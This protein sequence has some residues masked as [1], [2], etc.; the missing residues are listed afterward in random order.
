VNLR[1]SRVVFLSAVV[2]AVWGVPAI[3]QTLN[4]TLAARHSAQ[5]GVA[6]KLLLEANSLVYD[7]KNNTVTAVG[8]VE[9]YYQGRALQADRVIYNRTTQRV[10]AS[11]N[12]RLTEAD[13]TVM[14]GDQ[15][16]ITD[17]FSDGFIDALR[18][19]TKDKTRFS[20]ARGERTLDDSLVF[21]KGI[22]TAC[23][24]CAKDPAKPP[25]WQ[26]K[27]KRIVHNNTD[28]TIYYE[29]AWM[30]FAGIPV[31][32][33]PF[34]WSPDP[35]VKR[36]TGFLVPNYIASSALGTGAKIPFFWN[37]APNKDLTLTPSFLSRQGVL[38]QAEW[39]HRIW[40]G[41][42]NIRVAGIFQQDKKA[43]QDTPLGAS[44]KD[45]RGSIESTGRFY[46]NPQWSTGWHVAAVTDKWFLGN[47]RIQSESIA[48][49]YFKESISTVYLRG[50]N[51]RTWFDLRAYH[52]KGL[53]TSD[54][55][56]HQ[57]WV[58]PSFDYNTRRDAPTWLGGTI[59]LDVNVTSLTRDAA[60]FQEIPR[61][62]TSLFTYRR[63]DGTTF[64]LYD[65]CAVFQRDKCILRGI[66]GNTT[67]A[68]VRMDWQREW[69]DPIGQVW[70]P[71][72]VVRADAFAVNLD[73]NSYNNNRMRDVV[74]NTEDNALRTMPAVGLM[75]RYP[76]YAPLS[77]GALGLNGS[78]VL[79]PIAQIVARPNERLIGKLP[80][81]DAQS[82]VFDDTSLF[83]W[84]K[85]SGYDRA[86]GGVRAN[87]GV[88]H[89]ATLSNGFAT[90]VLFGQSRNVAGRNSFAQ[91][92]YVNTGLDSG[93]ETKASDY[94]GRVQL[95]P[96][97]GLSFTGR[98]R[99]DESNFGMRRMELSANGA[100]GILSGSVTYARYQPQ[101]LLGYDKRREGLW[102]T[103]RVDVTKNWWLSGGALFD[104][105]RYLT[106]REN[107]K[108]ALQTDPNA[109]YRR[110]A[111]WAVASLS[112]GAGYQDECTT[113]G[114][115]Y[116]S[117][118]KDGATG[119][120]DTAQTIL[121]RLDL[122]TLGTAGFQQNVGLA[123]TQDGLR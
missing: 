59:G 15:F 82:L 115:T 80:N 98:G 100:Y 52:F 85:F 64:G 74:G 50:Q 33:A 36:K 106:D 103:A 46:L 23:E 14:T 58:H 105:D 73:E 10:F 35:T 120:R 91:G 6:D 4:E 51:E 42:Y 8:E 19:Q 88:Q 94:V 70:Q 34:F 113:F 96:W 31:A 71:Y 111:P 75:Y 60:H 11:G 102:T 83:S 92:D 13:G 87:Y 18:V 65:T 104:L 66:A 95:S 30:E 24:P 62:T 32:Y 47:Y 20:A 3:A 40:T 27:A 78:Q 41:A 76:L 16:D 61:S 110:S 44:D 12:A 97:T 48:N 37:I 49:N 21:T 56:K 84:D 5:K 118:V 26:V 54:W 57:P 55:Q 109:V 99:F 67:R 121:V 119:T 29:D 68:S 114:V 77:F 81:E 89:S 1:F 107:Y 17:N 38:G 117:S 2:L 93:L 122:R 39:R 9:L 108:F 101:P 72:A 63:R 43:F 53:A 123:T 112:L 28:K 45:F 116:I 7:N 86:E 69:I 25:L 79:E 22:Y 90:N